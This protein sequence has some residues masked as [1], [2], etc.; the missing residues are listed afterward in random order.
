MQPPDLPGR[1]AARGPSR[2]VSG[3][4]ERHRTLEEP[5]VLIAMLSFVGSSV[6]L[7]RRPELL[8]QYFYFPELL[9]LTHLVTLGFVTSMSMG[10][11]QRL[12]PTLL[13]VQPRSRR[14]AAVQF[15]L[16]LVG[17][18][19]MVFHWWIEEWVGMG[20]ATL[21]VL[22]AGVVQLVNLRDVWPLA[23]SGNWTARYVAAALV[24]LPLAASAGALI[25]MNKALAL[26]ASLLPASFLGALYAH[27][28]L[29]AVGWVTNL[30]FGFQL[31]LVPTT[32]GSERWLPLRFWL[33]QGGLLGLAGTLLF[34][35]AG[36]ALFAS[37]V[38]AAILWHVLG[39]TRAFVGGR[40]REAALIP[41]WLLAL[42]ALAGWLMTAGVVDEAHPWRPRL[43]AAYGYLGLY[44]WFGL[45]I[46]AMAFKL[47]P[48]WVWKE[49]FQEHF[50]KRPVPGMKELYSHR[51][52][53]A[54]H[55]ALVAGVATTGL[56]ALIGSAPLLRYGTLVALLGVLGFLINFV[57]MARWEL[58][59]LEYQPTPADWVKFREIFPD[60][61]R[62][63]REASDRTTAGS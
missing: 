43:Q 16:F 61:D 54:A 1:P 48:M 29:A 30:I 57:R 4:D 52:K 7:S 55:A 62:D 23:R 31:E 14:L 60:A 19:G 45:T 38:V 39:P 47:F 35:L 18:S 27:I 6:W 25:G 8:L 3:S 56:G 41:L 17:G 22:A 50:G 10:V 15:G 21:L 26:D 58:L 40:L 59:K 63:G 37:A 44:G 36:A 5:F 11:L 2:G 9:A 33:L 20:W 51:L 42:C 49:R 12:L 32:K 28:H 24:G 53:A 46:V 34:D 13:S